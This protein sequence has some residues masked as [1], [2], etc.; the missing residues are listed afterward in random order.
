MKPAHQRPGRRLLHSVVGV[1]TL[2]A[3]VI[4]PVSVVSLLNSGPAKASGVLSE[5]FTQS[6]HGCTK[7]AGKT[8]AVAVGA[9]VC[10]HVQAS[11][12]AGATALG[13]LT[14]DLQF[15]DRQGMPTTDE[16]FATAGA[17]PPGGSGSVLRPFALDAR[18]GFV[19]AY[20]GSP[21]PSSP[22]TPNHAVIRLGRLAAGTTTFSVDVAGVPT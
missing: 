12:P 20:K 14:L 2:A 4:V 15:L 11:L 16:Y 5:S 13:G 19:P 6:W 9:E 17:G 7:P 21:S 10:Y 18:A 1:S 3:A 22:A 8:R